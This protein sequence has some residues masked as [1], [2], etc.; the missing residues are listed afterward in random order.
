MNEMNQI[1]NIR[2]ILFA[3]V[4]VY[5]ITALLNDNFL[6]G[7]NQG[8]QLEQTGLHAILGSQ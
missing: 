3:L 7:Y 8:K 4:A 5:V 2:G 1:K 6:G